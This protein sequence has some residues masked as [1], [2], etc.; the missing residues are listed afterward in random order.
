MAQKENGGF[1]A[2]WDKICDWYAAQGRAV[3][4]IYSLGA[5]VVIVGALFKIQH[6]P[7]AGPMLFAGMLTEALLF[8]MGIFE[9]P[10][11]TYNWENVYPQLI[12]HEV[13]EVL[14]GAGA[15]APSAAPAASAPAGVPALEEKDVK[16]LKESIANVAASASALADLGKLAEGS[17]KLSE[18]LAAAGE[19]ADKFAGAQAVLAEGAD[20]LGQNYVSAAAAAA[21]I[22]KQNE[23]AAQS[24]Q[25]VAKNV[26]ALNVAFELEL[27]AAQNA[28]KDAEAMAAQSAAALEA[29][30]AFAAA[31]QKLS[32]QVSD[33]NKI[34]GN[35]LSAI[36]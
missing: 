7:G 21:E 24:A 34:Y 15:G 23:A 20:K 4:M 29:G 19:A 32:Q 18:K 36:A 33:L 17:N 25:S 9:K 12:G 31:Q 10:H 22:G 3:G 16:A 30:K 11:P 6:L 14:G 27:K 8:T 13:K 28:Q 26:A 5:A 35:M 1:A 2:K